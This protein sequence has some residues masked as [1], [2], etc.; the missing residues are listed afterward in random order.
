MWLVGK[1]PSLPATYPSGTAK[2][3]VSI[4]VELNAGAPLA[5]IS[6]P[7]H[8]IKQQPLTDERYLISLVDEQA[9]ADRD[10]HLHWQLATNDQPQIASFYRAGR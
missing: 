10:F 3:Q 5:Q 7:S 2:S 1:A 9:S 8:D 4:Q 6:S